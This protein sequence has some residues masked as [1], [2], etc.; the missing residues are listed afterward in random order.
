M[1]KVI[2]IIGARP[3]FIKHAPVDQ[4]IKKYAQN[5]VIHTG[6]HFDKH[7]SDIF[8]KQLEIDEPNYNLD[9]H[10]WN[11]WEMTWKMM[12]EIEKVVLEEKPDF[13]LVYGDTNSTLAWALVWAKLHIPVIHVEAWLRS[14]DKKMPEEVNRVLTDHISTYLLAPT[15]QAIHNLQKEWITQWVFKIQ[16]PMWLTVNHFLP[17]AKELNLLSK[18]NLQKWGYYFLTLHRPSN[19]DNSEQLKSIIDLLSSLDKPVV[20][21]VHPRTRQRLEQFNIKLWDN[22]IALNPTW[23]LETLYFV[24]NS[25]AVLTDSWGLQKE[26]YIMWKNVFTIRNTTEWTET[27]KTWKNKLI[28]DDD[29]NLLPE[30]KDLIEKYRWWEYKD[31]YGEGE[32]LDDLFDKILS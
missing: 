20:F 24:Y 19:V 5:V 23:Y 1:K 25:D 13:I 17:K 6:Q 30:A 7:M 27:V 9:I 14:Y 21:P 3:Q 10:W 31:F 2:T 15:D 26:A 16:D 32:E 12:M 8:F 28:L 18:Y 4:I 22:I 29:W 11:H